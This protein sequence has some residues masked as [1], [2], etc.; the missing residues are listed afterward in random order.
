MA[1]FSQKVIDQKR[2][3]RA[4]VVLAERAELFA[5]FRKGGWEISLLDPSDDRHL[6]ALPAS[7]EGSD[8]HYLVKMP[9]ALAM[10]VRTIT[11]VYRLAKGV[12]A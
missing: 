11:A 3:E 10:R 9:G 8:A 5:K 7:Y 2:Q 6:V 12:Q 4:K 1:Q